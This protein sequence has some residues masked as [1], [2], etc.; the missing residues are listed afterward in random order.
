[1]SSGEMA[2]P[3]LYLQRVFQ[4][5][6]GVRLAIFFSTGVWGFTWDPVSVEADLL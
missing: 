5:S 4:S 1:M 3:E 6:T 2:R